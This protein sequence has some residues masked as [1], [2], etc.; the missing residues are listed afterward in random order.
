MGAMILLSIIFS[1]GI[2][3]CNAK[4]DSTQNILEM[5]SIETD[6]LSKATLAGGCFWCT[7]AIFTELKGVQKVV[8][9]YTG[10]REDN[11]TYKQVAN[12]LTGHAE[13]IQVFFDPEIIS[14]TTLLEVFFATH[15][16][17]TL[18]RQ[19]NDVGA[20][21]RSAIFYHDVAQ[22]KEAEN[23]VAYVAK[24]FWDDPIVTEIKVFE[25]FYP[26]EE[27]HVDYFA[28]NPGQPYC[29]FVI[30]PKV[31]K[32]RKKYANLLKS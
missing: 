5:M 25:R 19:G 9:G 24:E 22:Q 32:F 20:H 10:G 28:Q 17:T 8:P 30:N 31:Q 29:A 15:D 21:Y 7:E 4:P 26:A 2:T 3:S 13:A 1:I 11:P 18:N 6:S 16:P 23:A 14:Y 27:Y 12:G